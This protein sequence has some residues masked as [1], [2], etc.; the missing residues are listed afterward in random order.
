LATTGM[1]LR[2]GMC[3]GA[4]AGGGVGG[5]AGGTRRAAEAAAAGAAAAGRATVGAAR[6]YETYTLQRKANYW[7]TVYKQL[8]KFRLR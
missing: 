7:L 1:A 3:S 5:G 2:R 6:G 8:S 4:A